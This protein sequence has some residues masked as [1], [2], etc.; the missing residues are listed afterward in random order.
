[1]LPPI[2][3]QKNR[4][5]PHKQ[6]LRKPHQP[7]RPRP[8]R[9]NLKR[10]RIR[11]RPAHLPQQHHRTPHLWHHVSLHRQR[12]HPRHTRLH[13]NPK[14]LQTR[15]K[16]HTSTP[17]LRHQRHPNTKNCQPK[18]HAPLHTTSRPFRKLLPPK[19]NRITANVTSRFNRQHD[20]P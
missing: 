15:I 17:H 12:N 1:M 19:P 4:R 7:N 14:P 10:R 8:P 5:S 6:T 2:F 11:N 3:R 13:P 9:Q 20:P 18:H 16:R